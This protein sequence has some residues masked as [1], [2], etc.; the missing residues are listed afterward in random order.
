MLRRT[1]LF[2]LPH[3]ARISARG[4]TKKRRRPLRLESL[5]NRSLL[6]AGVLNPD[7]GTGGLVTIEGN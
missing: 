6:T 5:E 4:V 7:F 2:C 1:F 3:H